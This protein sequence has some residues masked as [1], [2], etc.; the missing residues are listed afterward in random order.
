LKAPGVNVH[1]IISNKIDSSEKFKYDNID[2]GPT[3][4]FN[5]DGDGTV[6][7]KSLKYPENWK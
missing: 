6:N 1:V 2:N 7:F 4:I 5:G 3:K